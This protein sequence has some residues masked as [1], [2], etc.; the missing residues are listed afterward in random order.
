MIT[1]TIEFEAQV[2]IYFPTMVKMMHMTSTI[3]S[4]DDIDIYMIYDIP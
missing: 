2:G 4:Y 3:S 1:M